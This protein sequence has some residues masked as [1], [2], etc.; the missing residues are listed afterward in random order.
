MP[1]G[2]GDIGDIGDIGA[3]AD[4]GRGG[5]N[6]R[7]RRRKTDAEGNIKRPLDNNGVTVQDSVVT[8]KQ[9]VKQKAREEE[10]A[11]LRQS[12]GLRRGR[13][14]TLLANVDDGLGLPNVRRPEGRRALLLG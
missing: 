14:A 12:R 13:R 8:Q 7:A 4:V 6:G 10:S 2:P 11:E 1:I 9:S 5:S 3:T